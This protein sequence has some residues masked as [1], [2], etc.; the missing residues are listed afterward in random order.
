MD[1][2][3]GYRKPAGSR[4]R[5]SAPVISLVL[6]SPIISEIL[7]GSTHIS[8]LYVLIPELGVW[9]CGAL[10]IRWIVRRANKGEISILLLGIAL[11]VAEECVIQQTSFFPLV[12]IDPQGIF[13]RAL[14]VNW[15]Y[16]LWAIG[17]E[18]IWTVAIPIQLT[19]TIFSNRRK[20]SWLGWRGVAIASIV[21]LLGSIIA[22]YSWT[23]FVVP[24]YSPGYVVSP[25][26]PGIAA[27][28]II[29]L[30]VIA[31]SVPSTIDRTNGVRKLAP[32]PWLVG[33]LT[34]VVSLTWFYLVFLAYFKNINLP[35]AIPAMAGLIMASGFFALITNWSGR[36]GWQD[37]HRFAL[38]FGAM[39]ASMSAGFIVSGMTLPIDFLGKFVMDLIALSLLV[40]LRRRIR[41]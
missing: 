16:L 9:G 25:S 24:L 10:L 3:L 34:F 26:Y 19:E 33:G 1:S 7:F 30:V 11:A 37:K 6:L 31:M 12:G 18:S 21:F 20:D 36:S 29:V 5:R 38:V 17:Y 28:V 32:L 2:E 15:I 35:A 13:G 14:G 22:W 4:W 23:R 8:N 27:I 40:F 39:I 41:N